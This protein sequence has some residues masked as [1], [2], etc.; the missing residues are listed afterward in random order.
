MIPQLAALSPR[1][2]VGIATMGGSTV[3]SNGRLG[4]YLTEI[5]S[6]VLVRLKN[7]YRIEHYISYIFK[8]RILLQIRCLKTS[9]FW[10]IR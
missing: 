2:F 8:N 3:T 1:S 4:G 6:P 5:Q 9:K 7:K 10:L